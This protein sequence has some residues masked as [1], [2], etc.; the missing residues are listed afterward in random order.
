MEILKPKN[1]EKIPIKQS[2]DYQNVKKIKILNI[3]LWLTVFSTVGYSIFFVYHDVYK[4]LDNLETIA[5]IKSLPDSEAINFTIYEE[6]KNKWE[7]KNHQKNEIIIKK[8]L[9]REKSITT[10]TTP[11]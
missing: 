8:N 1:N 7:E 9:F 11:N 10:T 3:F 4:S 2:R 6:T 5:T